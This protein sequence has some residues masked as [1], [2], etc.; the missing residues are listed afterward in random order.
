MTKYS[1]PKSHHLL[2]KEQFDHVFNSKC[3]A[4]DG[5]IIVYAAANE[6]EHPR[7]GLVVSKKV[8]TAVV[9][10]RWKRL[11]REAFRL[12]QDEL[13][14]AK[15]YVVLPRKDVEPQLEELKRSL[16]QVSR[17]AAGK[18]KRGRR[19]DDAV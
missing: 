1:F 18:I 12:S 10:N 11:L 17:R 3:S 4:A 15:D 19:R 2:T 16:I 7:L 6:L 5:R 14:P 13:P 8:G 9:R